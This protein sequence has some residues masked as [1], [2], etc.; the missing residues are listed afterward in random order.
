MEKSIT[1][2]IDLIDSGAIS[3]LRSMEGMGLIHVNM[4]PQKDMEAGGKLSERFAGA[5]R[6]STQKYTAFQDT[7]REGRREVIQ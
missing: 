1:L 4:P 3:L 5:L 7:I 2:T 6:L